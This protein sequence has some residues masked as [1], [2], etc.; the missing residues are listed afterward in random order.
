MD[1]LAHLDLGAGLF[2]YACAVAALA[3]LVKGLVGF[4]MPMVLISG[5]STA[6]PPDQALA[7]LILPTLVTNVWQALRQGPGEALRSLRK[8]RIF[9]GMGAV[10]MLLSAPLVPILP[11]AVML[12]VLGLPISAYA[13]SSLAGRPPRLPAK[14]GPR[15]EAGM[16]AL[17]GVFGGISG[18][19]GPPTVALLT[20]LETPKQEQVRVQG[21]VF[22]LGA[23]ILML[24]HLA[25]GVFNTQTAP[26]SAL[27]VV[28]S[29]VG[30]ALGFAVQDRIDQRLFRRLTLFVLLVAGLNLVRRGV[31]GF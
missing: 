3:G 23:V 9:L 11:G 10:C 14:P 24:A 22:G 13:L 6:F 29:L 1:S 2:A 12:M 15:T 26:L 5:L 27:L 31:M 4:A 16:G 21:V 18:V 28:P 30:M 17:A 25:S 8:F 7:M 20:A 19:W